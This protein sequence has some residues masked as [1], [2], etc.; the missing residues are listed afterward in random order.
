MPRLW[1]NS[2]AP[3]WCWLGS[4]CGGNSFTTHC[5]ARLSFDADVVPLAAG[6]MSCLL[7][8]PYTP[9]PN[10]QR[11]AGL[12]ESLCPEFSS[13]CLHLSLGSFHFYP[14]KATVRLILVIH[15]APPTIHHSNHLVHSAFRAI[16]LFQSLFPL[17][18]GLTTR[19]RLA[20]D[21]AW[22]QRL[23]SEMSLFHGI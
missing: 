6:E 8:F 15:F 18:C 4:C 16:R 3:A 23:R 5:A 21:L 2:R 19:R 7:P 1:V 20:N 22:P 14:P 9:K 13:F 11:R 17:P 12:Q 10:E